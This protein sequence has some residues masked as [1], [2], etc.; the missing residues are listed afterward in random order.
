MSFI[1]IKGVSSF[2][3]DWPH[4]S[5]LLRAKGVARPCFLKRIRGKIKYETK[6]K[7]YYAINPYLYFERNNSP[8]ILRSGFFKI[9]GIMNFSFGLD[10]L[11]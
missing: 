10:K 11:H 8:K 2:R 9:D 1:S 5:H 7:Y 4:G 3:V 6:I